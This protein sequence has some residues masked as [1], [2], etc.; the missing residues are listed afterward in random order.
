MIIWI[1]SYPRSG[2]TLTRQILK[3]CFGKD[4]YSVYTEGKVEPGPLAKLTGHKV[5]G[6]SEGELLEAARAD[7]Q[8]WFIKTHRCEDTNERVIYVVRDARAAMASY[9]HF[10]LAINGITF[11]LQQFVVGARPLENWSRHIEWAMCRKPR[12]RTLLLHYEDLVDPSDKVLRHIS[13]FT[14]LPVTGRLGN[15]FPKLRAAAPEFFG[16]GSDQAGIE[17]VE[18]T[19]PALFW[20][21]HG[22]GMRALGYDRHARGWSKRLTREAIEEL[23]EFIG[24]QSARLR[25]L[26]GEST[27]KPIDFA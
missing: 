1:A 18:A 26:Q 17:A 12:D 25:Q 10:Q 15:I 13:E 2:N 6:S 14:E 5:H 11:P 27:Q 9:Q 8:P 21:L 7:A 19:C 3:R 16:H 4:S 22:K 20:L 23:T 24:S